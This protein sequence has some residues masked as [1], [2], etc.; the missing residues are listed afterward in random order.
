MPLLKLTSKLSFFFL[1]SNCPQD[2]ENRPLC[3]IY[4]RQLFLRGARGL[5]TGSIPH[6][7]WFSAVQ[8]KPSKHKQSDKNFSICLD[9]KPRTRKLTQTRHGRLLHMILPNSQLEFI[10][11][12]FHCFYYE[13]PLFAD[14]SHEDLTLRN[15]GLH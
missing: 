3:N 10:L 11:H 14:D 2:F 6:A 15:T 5:A 12:M 8:I 4:A 1:T 13:I 7:R 9:K